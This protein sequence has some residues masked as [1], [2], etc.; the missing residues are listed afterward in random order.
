MNYKQL[1]KAYE[2][3]EMLNSLSLPVSTE[4]LNK[5]AQLENEYLSQEVIPH[6]KDELQPLVE[7][8]HTN[9]KLM[10][11]YNTEAGLNINLIDRVSKQASFVQKEK[12][13]SKQHKNYIIRVVFPNKKV[14]CSVRVWE[15]LM[16]VIHY[17]SPEKVQH[18]GIEIMGR[19]LVSNEPLKDDKFRGRYKEIKP[20]WYVFTLSSTKAKYEQVK[21]INSSLNL[22]L[23]IEKVLL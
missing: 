22:G 19:N 14:S 2:A 13:E 16:D 1:E 6:L 21:K 10:V 8:I 18:V 5:L 11:T 17:A 23:T 9:F 4:Q 12:G 7:R 20:G 15:T 3:I